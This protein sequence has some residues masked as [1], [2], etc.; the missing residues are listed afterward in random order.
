[1]RK[2]IHGLEAPGC[3]ACEIWGGVGN[4]YC[5][6]FSFDGLGLFLCHYPLSSLT[7]WPLEARP[8]PMWSSWGTYFSPHL[9]SWHKESPIRKDGSRFPPQAAASLLCGS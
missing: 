3:Q 8:S 7:P 2:Q 1:M 5:A 9:Q 4:S 6:S